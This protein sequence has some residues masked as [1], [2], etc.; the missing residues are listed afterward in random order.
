MA[1]GRCS[2][3]FGVAVG[4]EGVERLDAQRVVVGR[5]GAGL[6]GQ[7]L[8]PGEGTRVL[9]LEAQVGVSLHQ[10]RHGRGRVR[11]PRLRPLLLQAFAPADDVNDGDPQRVDDDFPE[12]D[13]A[14]HRAPH[15]EPELASQA[16]QQP[17][18][19]R[20]GERSEPGRWAPVP[21]PPPPITAVLVPRWVMP[22]MPPGPACR[23]PRLAAAASQR[24]APHRGHEKRQHRGARQ[25]P[26]E[27]HLRTGLIGP[28]ELRPVSASAG[29]ALAARGGTERRGWALTVV[30]ADSEMV[31]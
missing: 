3:G 22:F 17:D 14:Q 19:L 13:E 2:L 4:T 29:Q 9:V 26:S 21:D 8:V 5:G 23:A 7:R 31:R 15:P 1:G 28:A 11:V 10:L 27:G 16:R 25:T 12:L 20:G 6:G 30:A 24:P 18:D